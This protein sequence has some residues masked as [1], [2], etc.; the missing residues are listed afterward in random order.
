MFVKQRLR[1]KI[2]FSLYEDSLFKNVETVLSMDLIRSHS[3]ELKVETLYKKC[4]SGCDD[5]RYL[6]QD[7]VSSYAYGHYKINH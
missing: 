5:K 2:Y 3:H 6:K 7:G 1:K 4:L